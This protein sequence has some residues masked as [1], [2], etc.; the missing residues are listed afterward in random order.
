MESLACLTPVICFKEAGGATNLIEKT[1]GITLSKIDNA[2]LSPAITE[3]INDTP[4]ANLIGEK[5]R[6]LIETQF[7]FRKYL[8]DLTDL[9]GFNL[10]RISAIVPNYNYEKYIERRL[11]SIEKQT[12]PIYEIIVLDDKSTDGSITRIETHLASSFTPF[13]T[14]FNT[15]NSGSVFKQ[16]ALGIEHSEGDYIWIAEA[17]DLASPYFAERVLPSEDEDITISFCQSSQIDESNRDLAKDYLYYTKSIGDYWEH[18]YIIDGVEEIK[19]A[20]YIKNT[21]PNV[22]ATI[23]PKKHLKPILHSIFQDLV[24]FRVAGDW[25]LYIALAIHGKVK[26]VKDSLNVHRRH[27]NSVT[28]TTTHDSEVKRIHETIRKKIDIPESSRKLAKE[29]LN[30]FNGTRIKNDNTQ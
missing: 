3:L 6:L 7:Q 23:L 8:F 21:I 20:L 14:I 9:L 10:K 24:T 26:Y 29:F 17:D 18:D 15:I 11:E 19:R 4:R 13:K 28:H 25:F 30:S 1:G 12:Y 22:S 2:S 5:G 16:W 27:S